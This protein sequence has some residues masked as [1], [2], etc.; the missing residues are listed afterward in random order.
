MRLLIILF[1]LILFIGLIAAAIR[2][3]GEPI[4]NLGIWNSPIW[5]TI[6][7][8]AMILTIIAIVAFL[9]V[10]A[11][12]SSKK[13]EKALKDFAL[14]KGWEYAVKH[15]DP[16][17]VIDRLTAKLERVCPEKKFDVRTVMTVREGG[18]TVFLFSG[19]YEQREGGRKASLGSA[20]F[21]ESSRFPG[22]CPQTNIFPRTGLDGALSPR[23]VRMG[24]SEF[25]RNYIVQ[26]S[27]P[28]AAR[29]I[30]SEPLQAELLAQKDDPSLHINN[31]EIMLGLGGVVVLRFAQVSLD[32]WPALLNM[33]RRIEQAIR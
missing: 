17:G 2:F 23:Q 27:D 22:S 19:W 10:I 30:V 26:S 29:R 7:I 24:D 5:K 12:R 32:E 31:I 11:G 4:Y 25:A 28:D 16:Q 15:E 18:E 20:G 14:S 6:R 1:A 9:I 13:A 21:M 8:P 33:A 3:L